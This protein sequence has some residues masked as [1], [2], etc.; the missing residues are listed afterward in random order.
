[1]IVEIR[2]TYIHF[3]FETVKQTVNISKIHMIR[4]TG[5]RPFQGIR[6]ERKPRDSNNNLRFGS[7]KTVAT[8]DLATI[9]ISVSALF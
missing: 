6:I 4:L 5:D 8:P 1:M 7:S 3:Q 2:L 9:L